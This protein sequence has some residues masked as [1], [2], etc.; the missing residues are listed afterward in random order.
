[1][2]KTILIDN[3]FVETSYIEEYKLAHI[4]WKAITTPSEKY[5]EALTSLIDYSET[6]QTINF[7]SDGTDSGVITPDDRKWFQE[8]AVP[9]AAKNGLKHA[10][11]VIKPDPF[12][13]YYMN[14]ILKVVNRKATYNMKIF[15]K[16]EDAI[17]W[18]IGYND[19][20]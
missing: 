7:L 20:I 3:A 4:I 17:N 19:Y 10:A 14:A 13:K 9:K 18:L 1:M 15:N 16:Y 2:E 5:R 12:K 6:H 11:V 8:Y